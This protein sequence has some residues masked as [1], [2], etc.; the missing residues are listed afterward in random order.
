[1][2][3]KNNPNQRIK[4]AYANGRS[5]IIKALGETA[6]HE[7]MF[8]VLLLLAIDVVTGNDHLTNAEAIHNA[9]VFSEELEQVIIQTGKPQPR[10]KITSRLM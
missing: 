6:T 1:M 8:D 9:K 4:N 2:K 5:A 10:Q 7:E 3:N